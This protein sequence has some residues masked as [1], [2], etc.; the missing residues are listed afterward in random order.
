MDVIID[1]QKRDISERLERI[2]K[3]LVERDKPVA[4]PDNVQLVFNCQGGSIRGEIRV[5]EPV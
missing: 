5:C 1:G 3:W 2:I 4:T